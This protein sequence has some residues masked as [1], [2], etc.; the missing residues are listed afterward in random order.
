MGSKTIQYMHAAPMVD[1]VRAHEAQP[2]AIDTP[3]NT[4]DQVS[5]DAAAS[6]M[7]T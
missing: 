7:V 6:K 1:F 5:H 3:Q 4:L 2:C